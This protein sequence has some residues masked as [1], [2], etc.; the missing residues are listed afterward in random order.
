[1]EV[2]V[3][4]CGQSLLHL[5]SINIRFR[6]LLKLTNVLCL[7]FYS[8][9]MRELRRRETELRRRGRAEEERQS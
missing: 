6:L 7:F 8:Q 3:S 9:K 4:V 5:F 1:M 2:C